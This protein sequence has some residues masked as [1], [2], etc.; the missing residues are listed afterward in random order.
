MKKILL[1]FGC[2]CVLFAG[3]SCKKS[4]SSN[5]TNTTLPTV[6]SKFNSSVQ[7]SVQGD[8]IVLQ[9][10]GVPDHKSPYFPTTDSL[11]QAYNGT[12]T[13]V[14]NPNTI[15]TQNLTFKIPLNPA[16]NAAHTATPLGPIGIAINGVPLYNQYAGP[17]EPLTTEIVSFDQ[18]NGHPQQ[19]GQYH[20]HV[21]PLYI[22]SLKGK[23]ALIGFLLDG[24][25]VYGPEENGNILTSDSLDIYHGHFG[26]TADYP[27]GIYHYHVTADDPYINGVGFY[28]TEGTITQ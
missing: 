23:D 18:Y 6:F 10:N 25:P 4:S 5:T 16:V 9:S 14:K 28:G 13:F 22:T 1:S 17:N 21:E 3:I 15:T 24:F 2:C 7:I 26:P 27:N 20:Y 12:G 11:Y 8:Y 19:T